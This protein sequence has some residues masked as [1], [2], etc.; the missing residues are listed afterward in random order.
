[1]PS[2]Y[3]QLVLAY[4]R[5]CWAVSVSLLRRAKVFFVIWR[6]VWLALHWLPC[7]IVVL[8]R[9]LIGLLLVSCL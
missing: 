4:V 2:M 3:H 5:V 9:L 1:M 6:A 8:G 7:R